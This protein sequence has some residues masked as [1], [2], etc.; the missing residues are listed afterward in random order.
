MLTETTI[1]EES[2]GIQGRGRMLEGILAYPADHTGCSALIVGP[3]PFLGGDMR[4]NVVNSLLKALASRGAVT[5]AF[6]Y[7]GVGA[8]EGGPADWPS[9]ISTFWKE[10]AFPEE[11]DWADDAGSAIA[12]LR[13][14]CDF[15]PVLI[16]YSFGCWTVVR[17]LEGLCAKAIVLISPNPKQHG[18]DELSSCPSPLLLIHSDNDFTYSVSEMMTWFELIREPK[19]RI[20]LS[21]SEHFFRGHEMEVTAAVLEFLQHHQVLGSE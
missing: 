6:N 8:S 7:G 10:G 13:Q 2:V 4:N 20:Q 1:I 18:F 3:H 11:N 21:A 9:V 12:A 14:W 5:L 16:G 19:M 15:P 17:N